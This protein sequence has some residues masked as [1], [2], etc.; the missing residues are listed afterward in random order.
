MPRREPENKM[1]APGK[2]YKTQPGPGEH[3]LVCY[4]CRFDPATCEPSR[5]RPPRFRTAD[6][7]IWCSIWQPQPG[8]E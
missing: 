6:G 2:I 3:I 1:P 7:V 8:P 4:C 5:D